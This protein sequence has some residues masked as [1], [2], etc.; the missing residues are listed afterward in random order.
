MIAAWNAKE[1][2]L[3]LPALV[4]Q[5]LELMTKHGLALALNKTMAR[6]ITNRRISLIV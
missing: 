3:I 5:A 2:E 4:R 6:S 1:V